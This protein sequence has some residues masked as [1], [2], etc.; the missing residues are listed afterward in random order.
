MEPRHLVFSATT[1]AAVLAAALLCWVVIR[2][3]FAR[4]TDATRRWGW[5]PTRFG[6]GLAAALFGAAVVFALLALTADPLGGWERYRYFADRLVEGVESLRTRAAAF[7]RATASLVRREPPR[8]ALPS[9]A[10]AA[11][12]P[13]GLSVPARPTPARETPVLGP[14]RPSPREL[15]V[16]AAVD[17]R[18]VRTD[19]ASPHRPTAS[20]AVD[21][22]SSDT[23]RG[24]ARAAADERRPPDIA[25]AVPARS[26]PQDRRGAPGGPPERGKEVAPSAHDH[27]G[28]QDPARGN[29]DA[30]GVERR[31]ARA[32][33]RAGLAA[34]LDDPTR[35][36]SLGRLESPKRSER[37][38]K[39]DRALPVERVERTERAERPDRAERAER[40]DRVDRVERVARVERPDRI[41]KVERP[42]RVERV[43]KVERPE[44]VERVEKVQRPVRVERVERVERIERRGR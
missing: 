13:E 7:D 20:I 26:D 5:R 19:D 25:K 17:A 14:P 40:A 3:G 42:E 28:G 4:D 15:A 18:A 41:E 36:E 34:S 44:R 10:P 32:V 30:D 21:R 39:G 1:A 2:Y 23:A 6:H 38:E 22:T 37:L 24:R 31:P 16:T 12:M 35:G 33:P 43:E 8:S 27:R 9:A 29:S 11:V